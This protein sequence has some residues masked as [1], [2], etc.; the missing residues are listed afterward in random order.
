MGSPDMTGSNLLF[1]ERANAMDRTL[2]AVHSG[3]QPVGWSVDSED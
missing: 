3:L 2:Q 1:Q